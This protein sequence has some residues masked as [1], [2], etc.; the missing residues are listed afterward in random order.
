MTTTTD[1]LWNT[2]TGSGTSL[3]DWLATPAG[4]TVDAAIAKLELAAGVK[5]DWDYDDDYGWSWW[6]LVGTFKGATF[7]VY[8]HKGGSLHIGSYDGSLGFADD[9]APSADSLDT[10]GLKAALTALIRR[11]R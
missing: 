10:V 6:G 3:T 11:R 1:L 5:G 2:G 9:P 4:M 8:T 7:T